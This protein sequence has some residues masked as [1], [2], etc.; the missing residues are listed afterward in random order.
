MFLQVMKKDKIPEIKEFLEKSFGVEVNVTQ[1]YRYTFLT[2][3]G[4]DKGLNLLH[5]LLKDF[6]VV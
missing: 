3:T 1:N 5:T 6:K 2:I 4:D